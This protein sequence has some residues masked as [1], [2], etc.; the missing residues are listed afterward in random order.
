MYQV[1][2]CPA[3]RLTS[4][5]RAKFRAG[6]FFRAERISQPQKGPPKYSGKR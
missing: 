3:L 5:R 2:V 1:V 4:K 6:G